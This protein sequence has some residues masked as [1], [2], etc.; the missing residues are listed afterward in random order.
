MD[1][2]KNIIKSSVLGDE[3]AQRTLYDMYRTKW[4]M[5]AMRY[6]KNKTQADDIF[7]EGLIQIFKDLYQ[8]DE[9]KAAFGTWSTKVLVHAAIRYLKKY[10]WIDTLSEMEE[11]VFIENNE[12]TIYEKLAAKELTDMIQNLPLGYRLVFNMYVIEGYKH[13]E[14]A[15]KLSITEGTSKSQLSK[16][17]RELQ[18]QLEL[19]LTNSNH[20]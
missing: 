14:I 20:E 16:A 19:Q 12:E 10:N 7:Q 1:N 17:K 4:Y 18:K 13:R 11:A 9:S 8:F 3:K 5:M 2:H 15:E 6:G